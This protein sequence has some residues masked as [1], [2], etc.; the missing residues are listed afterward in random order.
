MEETVVKKKTPKYLGVL[1]L[2]VFLVIGGSVSAFI[3]LNKSS[4]IQYFLAESE[5]FKQMGTLIED[6]YQNELK[7]I[8]VQ[9]KKPVETKYDLSAELN[10]SSGELGVE[11]IQ[12]IVNSATLSMKQVNDPVKKELEVELSGEIGSMSL[13]LGSIFATTEKLLV[14]LPFMEELI[15]FDDKDFGK[16]MREIDE[17]YQGNEN[18]GLSQLFEDSFSM[19]EEFRTYVEKE[20]IAYF[21]KEIPEDAFTSEK[22]EIIVSDKKINAK[23]IKMDLSEKQVKTLLKDLLEK[24][25]TDEKLKAILKEQ[26]GVS[27]FAGD[28]S[29]SD[30]TMIMEEFENGLDE[31]IVGVD[32][33]SIPNGLQSTIWHHSNRIV[34]REFVMAIGEN[35]DDTVTFEVAGTQLLEKTA[36]QWDYTV[37]VTDSFGDE[38]VVEIKGDLAW[39]DNKANDSIAFSV[40]EVKFVYKGKE[41][42]KDKKRTFTRSLKFTDGNTAPS[43]IWKGNA[44]HESDS[45]KANHEFTV[46]EKSIGEDV[47]NLILK[48]QGKIVK[49]VDMPK[50]ADSTVNIGQMD[51]VEI[52]SFIEV[53]L[54]PKLEEWFYELT[55]DL[56]E[57]FN[58]F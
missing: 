50:E 55:G 54:M 12:S 22:E 28:F 33:L 8:E 13:D 7:W 14:S 47:F 51:M 37:G 17:D 11:E 58:D 10:D 41:E 1:F 49:E 42:L 32:S 4:K 46:S 44:T 16:L 43:F 15:R 36:Q 48:Q 25:R 24:A 56:E 38:N 5:T 9:R 20:Y 23:K 31:I 3:F 21:F 45:M 2:T 39:K 40:D 35:E 52:E 30:L 6:R 18:L 29:N 34:Q 27:A 53:E 57:E 19:T 26:L